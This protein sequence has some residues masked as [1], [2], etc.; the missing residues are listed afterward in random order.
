MSLHNLQPAEGSVKKEKESQEVK[1]LV[2]VVLLLEVT[3]VKNL[4]QGI[5]KK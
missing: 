1:V 4:D 2:K 5:L 3:M